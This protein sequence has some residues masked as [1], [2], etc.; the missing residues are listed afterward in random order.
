M[1]FGKQYENTI[2]ELDTK[3]SAL[4]D[5]GEEF[6]LERS[7]DVMKIIFE[8]GEQFI[9]T[10]QSPTSQLWLS[11]NYAGHRFNWSEEASDWT[12]EKTGGRFTNELSYLLGNKL[13]KA[14][15]L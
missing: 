4:I 3:L 14:I 7:G 13:E 9:I 15:E 5:S 2:K 12:N 1:D 10:P 11:A 6:D 8:D